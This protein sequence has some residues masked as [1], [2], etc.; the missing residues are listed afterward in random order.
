ML[1][2]T[3]MPRLLALRWGVWAAAVAILT[4]Q[5]FFPPIVG[6]S[7]QGDFARIIGRFGYGPEDK[8]PIW[9]AFVKRKYVPDLSA[10]YPTL[11]QPSSEYLF[12]GFAVASNKLI[13]RDG[14]LDIRWMGLVHV[15]A[16]LAAFGYLLKAT[17]PLRTAPLI[18]IASLLVLTD[19]G[20]AA[21]WN[22]FFSEPASCIFLVLVIAES[23]SIWVRREASDW[24][25]IRWSIWAA[26][27]VL[28]KSQNLPLALVLGPFCLVM[29]RFRWA[30]IVGF[31]FVV[32]AG[33]TNLVTVPKS[34]KIAATYN[35]LF[36]SIVPESKTPEADLSALGLDPELAKFSGTGAWTPR[37]AMYDLARTGAL[38]DRVTPG[39]VVRFYLVRPARMWR[40]A[41]V[42][43]P[44]AFSLRPEWCGNFERSAGRPPGA[45]SSSFSLWSVFHERVLTW[46]GKAIVV[47]LLIAPVILIVEWIRSPERGRGLE[48]ALLWVFS[49]LIALGAPV[50]GEA[51]DNIKH[52]FL[53]NLLID[54]GLIWA[55]NLC[56]GLVF[57]QSNN[58][59][60][61]K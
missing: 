30:G 31:C 40:H 49:S 2:S 29:A 53:F 34:L 56:V 57:L 55:A 20:Y 39:T 25:L 28:A 45:K 54:A 23:V 10:R 51:W 18:W 21:Y 9:S 59:R 13:S 17:A 4:F 35:V 47:M 27:L 3:E 16:F 50:Y 24:Q 43:L 12:T 41:K 7:D 61:A 58:E 42:M 19:V 26:L 37:T 32:L 48:F 60:F 38:G 22:S 52:M 44:I 14:K 8:T 15:T 46:I 5:L 1:F 36:M 11:E 6:L 33:I